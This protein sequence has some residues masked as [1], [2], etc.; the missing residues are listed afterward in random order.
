MLC[1]IGESLL[2]G[3]GHESADQA[4]EYFRISQLLDTTIDSIA[5]KHVRNDTERKSCNGIL[6]AAV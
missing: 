3:N 2:R 1:E 6:E 5:R 4:L